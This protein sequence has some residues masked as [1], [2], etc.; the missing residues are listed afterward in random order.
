MSNTIKSYRALKWRQS[1]SAL[2]RYVPTERAEIMRRWRESGASND[3][4]AL[5][6][7]IHRYDNGR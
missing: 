2:L 3:P 1:R 6:R 7:V 5:L 4:A